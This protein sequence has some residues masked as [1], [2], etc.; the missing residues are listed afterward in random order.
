MAEVL[1]TA[2]A[3]AGLISL[4]GK[5]LAEGYNYVASVHRAPR[6]LR[7]L[8]CESAALD[9]VLGQLQG[10]SD[11]TRG[12]NV[13]SAKLKELVN[14]GTI[15]E[16]TESLDLVRRSISRCQQI[17]GEKANNFGKRVIWP[18]KEKETKEI[19]AR[20]SRLRSHLTTALTVD[21]A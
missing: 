7:E 11:E 9:T 13:E 10:L 4:S 14:M 18:F 6:E 15:R 17:T 20:L 5:V 19:L 8:L 21:M 3:V 16:C 2:S 1:G 12:Y